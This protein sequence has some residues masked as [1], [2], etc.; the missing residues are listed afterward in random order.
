MFNFI[1]VSLSEMTSPNIAKHKVK[2]LIE[3]SLNLDDPECVSNF[4]VCT[5]NECNFYL[6]LLKLSHWLTTVSC[7]PICLFFREVSNYHIR[8]VHIIALD[9]KRV[10]GIYP[11]IKNPVFINQR[12]SDFPRVIIIVDNKNYT[13]STHTVLVL[14]SIRQ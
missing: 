12:V 4:H 14:E 3:F 13:N 10:V 11:E 5:S 2:R 8:R 7:I 6:R 1:L 9:A